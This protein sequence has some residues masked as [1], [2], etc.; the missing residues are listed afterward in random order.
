MAM[1]YTDTAPLPQVYPLTKSYLNEAGPGVHSAWHHWFFL[2]IFFFLLHNI[3]IMFTD[4]KTGCTCNDNQY[5]API[6]IQHIF[7]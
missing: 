5:I 7:N 4:D 6:H 1:D 3:Q 2:I